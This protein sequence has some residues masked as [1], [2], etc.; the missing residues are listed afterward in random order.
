MFLKTFTATLL[1]AGCKAQSDYC[2][3][4]SE[5]KFKECQLGN[6]ISKEDY[7]GTN[8][9][10]ALRAFNDIEEL[11]IEV[12]SK[13]K[14]NHKRTLSYRKCVWAALSDVDASKTDPDSITAFYSRRDIKKISCASGDD[15]DER[16]FWNKEH[17][18]TAG[19]FDKTKNQFPFS[20]IHHLVASDLS[21]NFD[22]GNLDFRE[23]PKGEEVAFEKDQCNKLGC[24]RS[25]L[26]FEPGNGQKGQVARML[27][28]MALRYTTS[29]Q[30]ILMRD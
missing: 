15:S 27:F 21:V 28:Y 13:A 11:T 14:K 16:D 17:I 25:T 30:P 4:N 5:Q 24:K 2:T 9:I 19:R 29:I 12:A 23:V 7:Y 8:W 18:F 20:D 1:I 3:D 22:R 10:T 26:Y 6:E